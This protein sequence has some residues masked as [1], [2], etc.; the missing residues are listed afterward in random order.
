MSGLGE[1]TIT[2]GFWSVSPF[3]GP[4][5][6]A[7]ALI[8][9][10]FKRT[11]TAGL[12]RA[13]ED[14]IGALSESDARQVRWQVGVG[15]M[16]F[17]RFPSLRRPPLL[18]NL[19]LNGDDSY[20]FEPGSGASDFLTAIGGGWDEVVGAAR[21]LSESFDE[22]GLSLRAVN[23]G[24]EE[25]TARDHSGFLDGTSNMQELTPG[26][27]SASVLVQSQDDET[28]AGGSHL[29]FR[30]YEEDIEMW[31]D[32]P[33]FVQ[34][35]FIG[36]RKHS[37]RFLDDV[38]EWSPQAW[39]A[40][41]ACAHVR[42]A[43]PR[44]LRADHIDYWRERIYRRGIKFTERKPDGSIRYGLLFLALV[45]DPEAQFARIHNERLLPHDA[46]KDFLLSSGY[47][48]PMRNGCYFL[49]ATVD[50]LR[51]MLSRPRAYRE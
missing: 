25:A 42:C 5:P 39:D 47:I 18:K 34:E 41:A 44:E 37:G 28:F 16:L 50:C 2:E 29:I 17:E 1:S 35:H 46:P 11:G 32:L 6:E 45:R 8:E 4:R 12:R 31:N 19:C 43:N 9:A 33:E 30:K 24:H 22:F 49:P 40:T 48:K 26:Q 15:P 23:L 7:L 13:V 10:D 21:R 36:R 14:L 27:F 38:E 3:T 20:T 51:R